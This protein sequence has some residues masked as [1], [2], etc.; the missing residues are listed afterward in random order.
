MCYVLT[1]RYYVIKYN[2]YS[3]NLEAENPSIRDW[4][5]LLETWCPGLRILGA[6][7]AVCD[8]RFCIV[9]FEFG[10]LFIADCSV[11]GAKVVID[12]GKKSRNT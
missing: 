3:Q 9:V 7:I 6:V 4:A 8:K 10:V 2:F 11:A 5:K 12:I 1:V